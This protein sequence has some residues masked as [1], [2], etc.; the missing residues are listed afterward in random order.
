MKN[1]FAGGVEDVLGDV[2]AFAVFVG[3]DDFHEVLVFLC[4]L[5]FHDA[6]DGVVGDGVGV[7]AVDFV[8]VFEGGLDVEH[9]DHDGGDRDD[10]VVDCGRG[11]CCP[12]AFRSACDHEVVDG[13]SPRPL[14]LR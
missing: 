14:C 6:H 7:A 8:V 4:A 2:E 13:L 10:A 11:P 3:F 1:W 5:P 9:V 12:A